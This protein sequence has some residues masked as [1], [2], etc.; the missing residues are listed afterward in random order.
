MEKPMTVNKA[1]AAGIRPRIDAL[2]AL[3][4]G[5]RIDGKVLSDLIADLFANDVI[6]PGVN[7]FRFDWRG[8]SELLSIIQRPASGALL[9]DQSASIKFA[10]ARHTVI[11]GEN[12]EVM[13]LLEKSYFGRIK[14]I[15]M[16]PP[17]N[18]GGELMF[19]DTGNSFENYQSYVSGSDFV[20]GQG[21]SAGADHS[22]WLNYIYARLFL[23]R[24]LLT[25]DGVIYVSIDDH[26]AHHL[27]AIMDEIFGEENFVCSFVWE[28][29]YSPPPDTKDIG[30][31]HENILCYRRSE[32]FAAG[33]LPMTEAQSGRY[34]NPDSDPRGP[35]KAADYTCRYTA[36][37][38]P[39]LY[40]PVVNPTTGKQLFP[41]KTR[42]WAC[43]KSEHEKNVEENRLWWGADGQNSIPAK[44]KY[45]FE[46]RQGAMPKT[47][48]QHEEVGH[49]DEA[50][51]E[52]RQHLPELKLSPKPKRL[53]KHLLSIANVGEQDLVLDCNAGT[54][55]LGEAIFDLEAE[56]ASVPAFLL[57]EFPERLPAQDITLADAMLKRLK[58][59]VGSNRSDKELHAFR[60]FRLGPSRLKLWDG[61]VTADDM[62]ERLESHVTTLDGSGDDEALFF[63]LMLRSGFPLSTQY[64]ILDCVGAKVYS[65]EDGALL[66]CLERKITENL[67]DALICLNPFQVIC[68][69]VGFNGSD[70]LKANAVQS[71]KA[72]S[73]AR[74]SEMRFQTI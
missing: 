27:R 55:S 59:A 11:E 12:L 24:N 65:V 4:D 40:Y 72:Q 29:R 62:I 44:K 64:K 61:N 39:T 33:L 58:S 47:I 22:I 10:E 57:V 41:K 2:T 5:E 60:M 38:R 18:I 53:M 69:D 21:M 1:P 6:S 34:T 30:Y 51:K 3:L 16:N 52:L 7:R 15:Y 13:K 43:S 28:K 20:D 35:W 45:L 32:D 74:A 70:E 66:I 36:E 54:G 31:V 9:P 19:N 46:I 25:A 8:K 50:T 17:F 14:M 42:V 67:I 63:E 68:L 48:L 56:G 49:T 37:E 73:E 23:A 26:E 71:F